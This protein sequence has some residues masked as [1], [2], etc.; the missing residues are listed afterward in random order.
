MKGFL[1]FVITIFSL[2]IV[3]IS[4]SALLITAGI[5]RI[6]HIERV[7]NYVLSSSTISTTIY[8]T[9]IIFGL[10]AIIAIIMS[11]TLSSKMKRSV[12]LSSELGGIQISNQTFENIII[13]ITKKY[14][15]IK[16]VKV[17]VKVKDGSL[18]TDIY[19]YVLQDTIISDISKSLQDDIKEKILK[20]TTVT[21]SN[22]NIKVKGTYVLSEIKEQTK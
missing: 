19:V 20:Q 8:V 7:I 21:V 17:E 16:T 10:I 1:K 14:S 18:N 3:L 13:G 15:G 2:I 11:D 12:K 4:S 6:N 22:V 5:L 9:S